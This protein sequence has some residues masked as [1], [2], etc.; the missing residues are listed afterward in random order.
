MCPVEA[1]ITQLQNMVDQYI[2]ARPICAIYAEAGRAQILS[3]N[4]RW[5]YQAGIGFEGDLETVTPREEE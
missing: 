1:Y 3:G 4:M 2:M 5:W